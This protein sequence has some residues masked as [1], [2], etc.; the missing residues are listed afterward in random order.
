MDTTVYPLLEKFKVS[1]IANHLGKRV[2]K[3]NLLPSTI[4]MKGKKPDVKGTTGKWIHI[5][6]KEQKTTVYAV[7]FTCNLQPSL[8]SIKCSNVSLTGGNLNRN[9]KGNFI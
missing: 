8:T 6:V 9:S 2:H 7:N 1:K 3:L 4:E 5:K